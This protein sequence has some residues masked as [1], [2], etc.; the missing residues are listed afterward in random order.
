[1]IQEFDYFKCFSIDEVIEHM[2]VFNN[3]KI[4]AGGTD[5]VA[6]LKE[7][8][9]SAEVLLDIK[10]IKKLKGIK[11]TKK[12]L[13]IG[14]L[15]TFNDLIESKIIK[16][17]F[18]VLM[19]MAKTVASK[20][21]RNRATMAGNICSAVPC[22]DSAP[23]LAA[24]DAVVVV[25]NLTGE[26]EIPIAKWFKGPKKNA[27]LKNELV[28]AIRIN[29]FKQN[30]AGCF[31]KL[32]RYQGEDLAQVN[33]CVLAL[34]QKEFRVV[35]GSVG[36]VPIRAKEIEKLLKGNDLRIDLIDSCCLMVNET[37][38]PI[39]DIRA[40][41]EYRLHMAK[42]MLKRALYA[43]VNRLEGHGPVYGE[44]HL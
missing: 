1:M 26:R 24:Y 2:A 17:N 28:T 13:E 35:F 25:T 38:F 40:T 7:N 16:E 21:I 30:H 22:M 34:S 36:P 27:L 37:I 31:L 6:S 15:V 33:L 3:S 23:V 43:A 10:G 9:V 29:N 18:P 41:K 12:M 39:T 20:A 14:S 19:E 8:H 32:G 11:L 42:V 44:Y 5:L 4:L